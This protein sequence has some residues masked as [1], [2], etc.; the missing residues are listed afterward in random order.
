MVNTI[1]LVRS[2]LNS[3]KAV[4]ED[5][6]EAEAAVTAASELDEKLI[7]L[8]GQFIQLK[9][10][11][12]GQ[13]VIRWPGKLG[14]QISYL[15][16]KISMTDFAPTDQQ[17]EVKQVIEDELRTHRAT[18]DQLMS[19]EVVEFNSMLAEQELQGVILP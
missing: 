5:N 7:E 4:L 19:V 2:Q 13:D 10:T 11:G 17:M 15:A 18:Y 9:L 16:G 1:E 14:R 6:E 8:E 12:R 3:L